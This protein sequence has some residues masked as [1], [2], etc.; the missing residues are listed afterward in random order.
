MN[1][2]LPLAAF[3][4]VASITPGPNNVMLSAS[5]ALFGFRRTIPHILGVSSGFLSLLASCGAGMGIVLDA[6]PAADDILR[7][8]GSI[9]LL[10]LAWK[11]RGAFEV[12]ASGSAARPLRYYEAF[13]FQF[14]NPKAWVMSLS[15]VSV[16]GS[17][18]EP[19]WL[20]VTT[21]CA[22]FLLVG[23]PCICSWAAL[24]ASIRPWLHNERR[25]KY[26]GLMVAVLATYSVIA[27]WV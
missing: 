10:Y 4:F 11:M 20:G 9:Y 16:F 17:D 7:V 23:F 3:A 18:I 24:G 14:I 19:Y 2:W 27:L 1:Q 15:A 5:G 22:T 6:L 13:G 25:R 21:I 12:S 8:I 26:L